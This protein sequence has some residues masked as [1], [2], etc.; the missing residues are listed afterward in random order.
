MP[1]ARLVVPT[2]RGRGFVA[3]HGGGDRAGQRDSP[4]SRP[5]HVLRE[6][7]RAGAV[8][9]TLGARGAVLCHAGHRRW[10]SPRCPPTGDTCGAGDRFAAT[11]A[12]GLARGLATPGRVRTAVRAATRYVA[13]N[14]PQTLR[15]EP[16]MKGTSR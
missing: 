7:W 4:R 13:A 1:G 2:A 9:V 6:R 11:A 5:G 14:G 15:R 3:V 10:S 16:T 12:L 8:A